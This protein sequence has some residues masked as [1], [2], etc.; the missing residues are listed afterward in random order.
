V[1]TGRVT[2]S[3]I[4]RTDQLFGVTATGD[5]VQRW[6]IDDG[7][8]RVSVL[9]LGATVQSLEVPDGAGGRVDIVLGFDDVAGYQNTKTFAGAVVG[10]LANRLTDARFTLDGVEHEIVPNEGSVAL[11]GG[12]DGFHRRIWSVEPYTAPD[13]G[14]EG[15]RL[16]LV[17]PDG[18]QGFPGRLEVT[19]DYLLVPGRRTL[20]IDYRATTDGP[21]VVNLTQHAY[22]NLAGSLPVGTASSPTLDG[23]QLQVD[24]AHYTPVDGR[25]LPSGEE[26][27]TIGTSFDLRQPQ[28]LDFLSLDHNLIVGDGL[29]VPPGQPLRWT[30]ALE[31]KA[32]GRRLEVLSTEPGIQ[33]YTGGGL[34]GSEIGKG[35]I[36]YQQ[37]AAICLETQH[38]P[39]APNHPQF[40]S[41][42]LRPGEEYVSR[43]EWRFGTAAQIPHPIEPHH[44][45]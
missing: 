9:S 45:D 18:D 44:H 17:S 28:P 3:A 1:F 25:L 29:P 6:T 31:H 27:H 20:R 19:V 8:V 10:R 5:S 36:A 32:S 11:H 34:D 35:G 14:G 30:A 33:V 16:Q 7:E 23:Q 15:L 26:A 40:P 38:F 22:F 2:S 4:T 39:D 21:T 37:G 41:T 43:T 13:G 24:A 42:T 12:L